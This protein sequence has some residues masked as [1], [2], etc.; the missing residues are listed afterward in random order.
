MSS[1]LDQIADVVVNALVDKL[2][3]NEKFLDGIADKMI[4]KI[5]VDDLQGFER[6]VNTT[7]D[8]A[9]DEYDRNHSSRVD[10]SDVDGLESTVESIVDQMEFGSDIIKDFD[11]AVA[12]SVSKNGDLQR[13]L[14]KAVL[15][16]LRV[17]LVDRD[18][19]VLNEA[20]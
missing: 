17:E 19:A 16:G 5:C 20:A 6:A 13:E 8:E 7:V 2:L 12:D 1:L 15:G 11:E 9:M 4:T 18:G 14:R 10:V 3:S